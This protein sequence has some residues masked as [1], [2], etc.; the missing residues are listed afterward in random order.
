[1]VSTEGLASPLEIYLAAVSHLY[2]RSSYL[3]LKDRHSTNEPPH[4]LDLP[5]YT[6][7]HR[8]RS[9][10]SLLRTSLCVMQYPQ[11]QVFDFRS[12][13]SQSRRAFK[14]R[15]KYISKNRFLLHF[16]GICAQHNRR[17]PC[18]RLN[19]GAHRST[20]GLDARGDD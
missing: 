1:M 9:R 8:S 13:P 6:V 4:R 14:K 12:H 20:R 3:Q 11:R 2:F 7:Q 10:Q 16:G 5:L 17:R 19:I 15:T 18:G